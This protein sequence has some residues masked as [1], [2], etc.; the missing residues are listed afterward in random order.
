M[1]EAA[2]AHVDRVTLEAFVSAIDEA[3]QGPGRDLLDRVCD[4][5][6]FS[7][8]EANRAWFIEHG[9]LSSSQSKG[10]V[11]RVNELCGQ[12]RPH[13]ATLV[14]GFGIPDARL[15][16]EMMADLATF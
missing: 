6:V 11:A 12:L 8:V 3:P 15:T 7:T 4:L 9:R 5:F 16:T 13:A 10:V 14:A 2:R 1:L